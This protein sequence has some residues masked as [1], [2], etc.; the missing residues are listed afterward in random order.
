MISKELNIVQLLYNFFLHSFCLLDAEN[1]CWG[2]NFA[3]SSGLASPR[4][5]RESCR[6]QN[7]TVC[8]PFCMIN[9]N[10]LFFSKFEKLNTLV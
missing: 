2:E 5:P 4:N 9:K 1:Y 3:N 7:N 6:S 8:C 10:P